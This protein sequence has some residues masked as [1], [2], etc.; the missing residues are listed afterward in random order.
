[1]RLSE[2]R[3]PGGGAV[4]VVEPDGDVR[5]D[6]LRAWLD[7]EKTWLS[8]QLRTHGAVLLR[9]FGV[10]VPVDLEHVARAID[11]G[12]KN[13]Y[14]GTS[15]RDA[16][17]EYVF[18]ASELPPYYPIPQHCEMSFLRDPPRRLFFACLVAPQ[19]GG[20][21]TPL[22]DFRRVVA[23]LDPDVR[24]RFVRGGIRIIRNYDGPDG[25][26]RFD[27]WKLKRWD[28]MFLTT[29]RAVVEAKCVEQG[30]QVTWLAGQRLRL[31]SEHDALR[32]HPESGEPVWFNH[33]QVFHAAS[34]AAELRR[35]HARQGDLRSLALSQ[36][37]RLMIGARRRFTA[38]DALP[39][40]C[41]YRDG[42]EIDAADLEHL[43]DVVWRHMVVFPW[44]AGDVVAID[45]F[46]VSHGRLPYRG[47][48][49]VVVAWA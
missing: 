11:P 32:A 41:T 6:A 8:G 28:E 30:F 48:R 10:R 1:M 16:L 47:P 22:C 19:G 46:S 36:F 9:G 2:I 26:G 49:Q 7:A 43:R 14:L 34:A 12:L 40:H 37:A 5:V 3:G 45:N 42:R 20:G 29:D 21:E 31:V 39:M 38:A 24:D 27:L 4:P 23:D 13:E 44:R 18:S 33:V 25:G 15:P 17:S 35:V